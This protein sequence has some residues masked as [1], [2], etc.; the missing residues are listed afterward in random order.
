MSHRFLTIREAASE[1]G[2]GVGTLYAWVRLGKL[3][4]GTASSGLVMVER[5][6]V[7]ALRTR[8]VIAILDRPGVPSMRHDE[9]HASVMANGR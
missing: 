4:H 7:D 8:G 3:P 2:I 1:L 9:R 5:P 6:W